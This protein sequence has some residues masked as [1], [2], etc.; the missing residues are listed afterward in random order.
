MYCVEK[1]TLNARAFMKSRAA[2]KPATGLSV[3]PGEQERQRTR[4]EVR[5]GEKRK[6]QIN[7]RVLDCAR[8]SFQ[9][10]NV[11]GKSYRRRQT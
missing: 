1:K 9:L 7:K 2:S 6:L 4:R 11:D 10:V 3:K 5:V 8:L